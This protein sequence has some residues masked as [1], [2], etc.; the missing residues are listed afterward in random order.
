MSSFLFS[1]AFRVNY[2][3]MLLLKHLNAFPTAARMRIKVCLNMPYHKK[4]I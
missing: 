3:T 2:R 1:K 4:L